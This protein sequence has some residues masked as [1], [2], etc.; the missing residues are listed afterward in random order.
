MSNVGGCAITKEVRTM[1]EGTYQIAIHEKA[2]F[3]KLSGAL[4]FGDCAVLDSFLVCQ[5]DRDP[6]LRIP[7]YKV[8]RP[9]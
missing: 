1:A 3:I 2:Y 8:C 5:S 7:V 6:E 9:I 4:K